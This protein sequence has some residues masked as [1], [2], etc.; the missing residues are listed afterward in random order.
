[1]VSLLFFPL[2]SVCLIDS[3]E[4]KHTAARRV[5]ERRRAASWDANLRAAATEKDA[6][7]REPQGSVK[8]VLVPRNLPLSSFS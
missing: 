5:Q 1:M 6:D 4:M 3:R 8:V 2:A 7:A